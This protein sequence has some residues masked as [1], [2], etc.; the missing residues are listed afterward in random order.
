M[1]RCGNE[2]IWRFGNEEMWRFEDFTY[3][4]DNTN[5]SENKLL[6]I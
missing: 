2:E 3:V 6:F 4:G 5:S 1:R